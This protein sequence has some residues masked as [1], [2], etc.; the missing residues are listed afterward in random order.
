MLEP[1][2]L[3]AHWVHDLDPFAIRLGER[4][5][6][7]WY[8]LAYIAGFLAAWGLL[9]W[10][11]KRGKSPFQP[12]Q[13]EFVF[14]ALF[15]GVIL[16]GRLGYMFLYDWPGFWRDP[17]SV[18][19]IWEGGMA[20][21]GGFI[22][23]FL[24]IWVIGARTGAGLWKSGDVITTLAA[25]GLFFGRI[26]NFING[27]LWGKTT[28]LPWGVVFP[29]SAP[30]GIPLQEIAARH[31]SQLYA[32][33]LEGVLLFAYSQWR[34]WRGSPTRPPGQLAG[35]ILI[36]YAFLRIFGEFFREPDAAL[37]LGMSRGIF[38]SLLSILAGTVV[39]LSAH[40][41]HRKRP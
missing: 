11:G 8:S 20:S 33:F 1:F 38:Y 2:S 25:P 39:I 3:L 35:E 4:F 27:E 13:R 34:F 21:H 9:T 19:R 31:P 5:G 17:L 15:L 12:E 16:G 41:C 28:D 40:Y 30:P 10:Y 14:I 22:G 24:A 36:A 6:I 23:V 29:A 32:A 37:I 7:R 26:A 18:V